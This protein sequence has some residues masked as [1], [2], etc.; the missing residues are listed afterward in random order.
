MFFL[1]VILYLCRIESYHFDFLGL[2]S[3]GT[4]LSSEKQSHKSDNQEYN[5]DRSNRNYGS[6]KIRYRFNSFF[7]RVSFI[8][9]DC[10]IVNSI[11][12]RRPRSRRVV[13]HV[14]LSL[15]GS[16]LGGSVVVV[17][18]VNGI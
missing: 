15:L 18:V 10:I 3:R 13:L 11:V 2:V 8:I 12:Y 14:C 17:V 6:C 7:S 4:N 5:Q 9:H 1:G 16:S